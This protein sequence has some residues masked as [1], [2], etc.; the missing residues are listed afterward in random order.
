MNEEEKI[1]VIA[2]HFSEEAR[3]GKTRQTV[4]RLEAFRWYLHLLSG[5]NRGIAMKKPWS[6]LQA[7]V[8]VHFE[9][10]LNRTRK[11]NNLSIISSEVQT[12]YDCLD[13]NF[14]GSTEFFI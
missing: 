11:K 14:V 5:F 1:K 3:V 10:L 2:I 9:A 4:V 13:F 12:I 8:N 7:E 6:V